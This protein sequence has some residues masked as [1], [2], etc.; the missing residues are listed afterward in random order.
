MSF[1]RKCMLYWLLIYLFFFNLPRG[2]NPP[3]HV[4]FQVGKNQDYFVLIK[5]CTVPLC[6]Y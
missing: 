5:G 1:A 3:S 2:L 4:L 6:Y